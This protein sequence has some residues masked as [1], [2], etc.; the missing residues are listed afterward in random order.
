MNGSERLYQ[1][2][3][4]PLAL[5]C[6]IFVVAPLLGITVVSICSRGDV[7]PVA[8]PVSFEHYGRILST[9]VTVPTNRSVGFAL[10]TTFCCVV[11]GLP[12]ALMI[13]RSGARKDLLLFLVIVPFLSNFLVRTYAWMSLLRRD[14]LVSTALVTFGI[15]DEPLT[16]LGTPFAIVIGLVYLY[17]PFMVI[18]L[19]A[20]FDRLDWRLVDAARDLGG[21]ELLIVR[22]VIFPLMLPTIIASTVLVAVL[23]F[24]DF[25]IA[26][27]LGGAKHAMV[28]NVIRDQFLTYRNWPFG[29]AIVVAV[30]AVLAAIGTA[31]SVID[32]MKRRFR[33]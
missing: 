7:A 22:R 15:T 25:V 23:S 6:A 26:D 3:A 20:A 4:I 31:R 29:A 21:S 17:L 12:L 30:I 2:L 10:V 9:Q 11:I 14:G 24:G 5:W 13:S 8:L 1:A 27:L 18:P 16:M 19:F 32:P 33:K 28:G